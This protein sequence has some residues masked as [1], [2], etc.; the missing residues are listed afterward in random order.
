MTNPKYPV[1]ILLLVVLS[2][3][4]SFSGKQARNNPV[5]PA[6]GE[7]YRF[8]G[9]GSFSEVKKGDK[10]VEFV[11]GRLAL[12]HSQLVLVPIESRA[13]IGPNGLRV[14]ISDLQ[15]VGLYLGGVSHSN[16]LQ[17][18]LKKSLLIVHA[19][20]THRQNDDLRTQK[21]YELLVADGV[22]VWQTNQFYYVGMDLSEQ[23]D[24]S[25]SSS[26]F[27][28]TAT[29]AAFGQLIWESIK[30]AGKFVIRPFFPL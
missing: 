4:A 2:G 16:Q 27:L 19:S 14:P 11:A 20:G 29:G 18:R 25:S 17:I 3:C 26:R 13:G 8:I 10:S 23:R 28:S 24:A 7:V 21:L 1:A 9:Q 6:K 12:T 5:S 30:T 15:E 22:P